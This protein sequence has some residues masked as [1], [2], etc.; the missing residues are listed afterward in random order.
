MRLALLFLR[1][2]I[3]GLMVGH[4]LQKLTGSFG[5]HGLEGT[6]QFFESLGL[7]PGRRHAIA[8]GASEAGG[9][10]LLVAGVLTPATVAVL[11]G[12][13]VTAI[14][15]V[16]LK[17]GPWASNGGYEYN[18]VLIAALV[19]LAE[20]GPGRLSIDGDGLH[21]PGFALAALAAGVAGSEINQ[22]TSAAE[23]AAEAGGSPAA[24]A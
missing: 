9:G 17:N 20:L 10:A 4:G 14:R 13:Q 16:H 23:P 11:I 1:T 24:S 22:R 8:A 2:L 6:G 12:V 21:G 18:L 3:G 7:R 5:G 19:A 15:T